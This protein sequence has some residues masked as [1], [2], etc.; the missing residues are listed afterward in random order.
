MILVD[1]CGLLALHEGASAFSPEACERL[2]APASSVFVSA[3]T[4]FEI[5][6]KHASGKL[7]LPL[8]SREWFEATLGQ[9][10][11]EEL[12]VSSLIALDATALPPIHRDPF[13]RI[14]VATA[15]ARNLTI[16]TCDRIIPLYPGVRTLW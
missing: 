6:Q 11:L 1:A 15:L 5:G 4:A 7:A 13:D 9:H 14:V 12:P 3:I 8:P 16:L 2:E 10:G